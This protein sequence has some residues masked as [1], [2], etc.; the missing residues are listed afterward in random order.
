M[1][2]TLGSIGDG[3]IKNHYYEKLANYV[4][5]IRFVGKKKRETLFLIPFAFHLKV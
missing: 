1:D 2:L 5:L 4:V 3:A